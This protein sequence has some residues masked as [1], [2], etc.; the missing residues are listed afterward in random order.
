MGIW[1]HTGVSGC[2]HEVPQSWWLKTHIY[3]SYSPRSQKPRWVS[4]LKST[5]ARAVLPSADS[6]GMLFQLSEAS[7]PVGC[8][9]MSLQP[10]PPKSHLLP[11]C[12]TSEDPILHNPLL[13]SKSLIELCFLPG[14]V[15]YSHVPEIRMWTRVVVVVLLPRVLPDSF[16]FYQRHS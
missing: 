14:E 16:L 7:T 15:P 1:A 12:F 6:R 5:R 2:C 3:L 10:L 4:W 8:G 11:P 13:T 9:P